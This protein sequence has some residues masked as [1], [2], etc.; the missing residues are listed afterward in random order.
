MDPSVS[1]SPASASEGTRASIAFLG[2]HRVVSHRCRACGATVEAE[3]YARIAAPQMTE[4]AADWVRCPACGSCSALG[5]SPPAYEEEQP[6]SQSAMKY[7]IEQNAAIDVLADLVAGIRRQG[8]TRILDVGCG[9]GFLLDYA[10]GV[11]GWRPQGLD[12]STFARVGEE[13][14]GLPIANEYLSEENAQRYRADVIVCSEII[15]HLVDPDPFLATLHKT[16]EPGGVLVMTT[17]CADSAAPEAGLARNI[18]A[19]APGQHIVVYSR[20]GLETALRRAGFAYVQVLV[21]DGGVQLFA[22][23]SDTANAADLSAR[24]DPAMLRQ[25][26]AR[27]GKELAHPSLRLGFQGRA[28]K[29]AVAAGAW[30]EA[31]VYAAGLLSEFASAGLDLSEPDKLN[32]P[33]AVGFTEFALMAPCNT[34]SVLFQLGRIAEQDDD[35]PAAEAYFDAA[36]RFGATLN[37]HL[38]EVPAFDLETQGH[39]RSARA[40]A[41]AFRA[42]HDPV[43]AAAELANLGA[44][45]FG[46]E[47][48]PPLTFLHSVTSALLAGQDVTPLAPACC[49][50]LDLVPDFDS[51]SLWLGMARIAMNRGADHD[52]DQFLARMPGITQDG[53]LAERQRL[54]DGMHAPRFLELVA[55][56]SYEAA[57]DLRD[58]LS[59]DIRSSR[60]LAEASGLLAL[61]FDRQPEVALRYFDLGDADP[62]LVQHAVVQAFVSAVAL[63]DWPIATVL[64]QRLTPESLVLPMLR[65][66]LGLLS[67][68]SDG[69]PDRALEHFCRAEGEEARRLERIAACEAFIHHSF[70]GDFGSAGLLAARVAAEIGDRQ[71]PDDDQRARALA[72]LAVYHAL[73]RRDETLAA[74]YAQEANNLALDDGVSSL[75]KRLFPNAS[76]DPARPN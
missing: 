7:Y 3:V 12:P 39:V 54:A 25:W 41:A 10:R 63:G 61:N 75:L 9:F 62:A 43:E 31:R 37:D 28:L 42:R 26:M 27:R 36:A 72:A 40:R 19:Y 59:P 65:L 21:G 53:I 46:P 22:A 64:R 33:P 14:L 50:A 70:S 6:I 69:D 56:G 2:Q 11:L 66:P 71:H 8:S 52:A 24:A 73:E 57:A 60:D 32:P 23:A 30:N 67:L 15:E 35:A 74:A 48:C 13:L 47:G 20:E 49:L 44:A 18:M 34:G 38:Q 68:N 16:L 17:P 76:D 51:R 5:L 4:G 55:S 1:P 58:R 29:L 45:A